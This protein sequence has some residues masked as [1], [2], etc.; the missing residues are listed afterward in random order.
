MAEAA[1][2]DSLFEA[3][4]EKPSYE[5]RFEPASKQI[6]LVLAGTSVA[7]SSRAMILRETRSPPVY[8]LPRGDVRMD[9]LTP[10]EHKTFCPFKGTA[11]YWHIDVGEVRAENAV[12]S[13]DEPLPEAAPIAGYLAFY[14]SKMDAFYEGEKELSID[15][16]DTVALT[17]NDLVRW[18]MREAWE[19]ADAGELTGRFARRLVESGIPLFRLNIL[20]GTLNPLVAGTAYV[21]NRS[22][23]EVDERRIL[24][25]RR[26]SP[27]YVNSPLVPIYE[28]KGGVRRRLEGPGAVLDFPI[29][30]DLKAEGATDYVAMPL[31]FS[32]GHINA[33]TLATT[34]PGGFTTDALGRLYEI[35]PL[36]SRLFEVH[37]LKHTTQ[38]LMATYLGAHTAD[39]VLGGRIKRG[40]GENIPA[41]IWYADLR[42][43][44]RL[45][46]QLARD[47]Y[48]SCLNDFFEA[49]A[50]KVLGHGG[51]VL[52]FIGD[53]V[54]AIFP[55]SD[56]RIKTGE[57]CVR[58]LAAARDT[59]AKLA[60][61]NGKY[62][63]G[64][65][66]SAGIALHKG[67]VTYGNVGAVERL[68]FTVIG[69]AANEVARLGDLCKELREPILMSGDVASYLE[70]PL[71]SLG[72][73]CLR[74][75][76]DSHE[77]FTISPENR[78]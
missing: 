52:K 3:Q 27:A 42:G 23:D 25:S 16:A 73:H 4:S 29:L 77:I 70:V 53:A 61:I 69:P 20:L 55:I 62:G 41:V 6:N 74:G 21:W 18:M 57:A 76:R 60:E 48:L 59:Q 54:L 5:I 64:K 45:A 37:A 34:Q 30:E 58:A 28:G 32:D 10:S 75:V 38:S 35:L 1:L 50:G 26:H 56:C 36:L 44:T 17:D 39:L 78:D 8:Y 66:L 33:I 49:A 13:Y 43:S 7:H 65:R 24:H 51:E 67:E 14:S 22:D 12:W 71:R 47:E 19:A 63:P 31:H 15:A 9:L 68:D 72:R 11:S 40:D 46:G 2:V